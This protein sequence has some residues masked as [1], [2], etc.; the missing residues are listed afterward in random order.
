MGLFKIENA[1]VNNVTDLFRDVLSNKAGKKEILKLNED[2][3]KVN[4]IEVISIVENIIEDSNDIKVT[5]NKLSKILNI[6][7][8]GIKNFPLK[9]PSY[10]F[11]LRDMMNENS[12]LRE[13]LGS[14][15]KRMKEINE[16]GGFAE[17][18]KRELN[19][20]L[21][22]LLELEDIENHYLKKENIFFPYL[23]KNGG[24]LRC[25]QIMWSIH[26]DVRKNL[27]TI[28]K[29]RDAK[30]KSLEGLIESI[31]ELFFSI[32]AVIFREEYILYPAAS[33][34]LEEYLW[35][36]MYDESFDV[37]FSFI[38]PPIRVV[39]RVIPDFSSNNNSVD[40]GSGKVNL[41]ILKLILN[42]LPLDIT[43]V[44]END[45]VVYF[46]QPHNRI[47]PRSKGI[48]GREVQNCHPPESMDRVN[49][50]LDSFKKG[51]SSVESFRIF[52]KDRYILIEYFAIRDSNDRY[53]GTL[54]V[55]S[56]I[57]EIIKLKGEK[58]L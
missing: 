41:E 27:E 18:S 33:E 15:K 22:S 2:I 57:T 39:G 17:L 29:I 51:I 26:D 32:Y 19:D 4:P 23:E 34:I 53:R 16:S 13:K 30:G 45:K 3:N 50:I 36:V 8:T 52:L 12:S 24:G 44:D 7:H 11:F 58:R 6:L 46:S 35:G 54:E 31:G 43:F 1:R 49:S 10:N 48:I 5:K 9:Y 56:D 42:S 14:L 47:F 38:E 20:F 55:T 37:G 25:L 40:T 21:N 28:K